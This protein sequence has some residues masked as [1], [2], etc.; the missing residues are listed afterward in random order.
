ME[1]KKDYLLDLLRRKMIQEVEEFAI[2]L[3]DRNG[4]ILDWN[5]GAEKIKGYKAE[6]IIGQNFRIF[7]LPEDRQNNLPEKLIAEA[8]KNGSAK[9]IGR[10]IKNNGTIFYGSILITAIHDDN[11]NVIGFTKVTEELKA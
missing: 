10:R 7:Y 4:T 8:T 3:L 9:H 1:T 5:K 6:E 2:I 11:N